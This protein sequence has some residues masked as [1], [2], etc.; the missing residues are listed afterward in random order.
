VFARRP[1]DDGGYGVPPE[2]VRA[3]LGDAGANPVAPTSCAS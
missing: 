1:G 2:F 3:T